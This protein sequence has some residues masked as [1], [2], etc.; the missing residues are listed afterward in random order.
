ME[1]EGTEEGVEEKTEVE[2]AAVAE[3]VAEA[4]SAIEAEA[5]IAIAPVIFGM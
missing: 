3:E 5:F 2:T 1:E 4:F